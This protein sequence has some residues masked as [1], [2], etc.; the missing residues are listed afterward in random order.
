MLTL[1]NIS[2]VFFLKDMHNSFYYMDMIKIKNSMGTSTANLGR[3]CYKRCFDEA[4]FFFSHACSL[5]GPQ[6][7]WLHLNTAVLFS[8]LDV[9]VSDSIIPLLY[10]LGIRRQ[11]GLF[12]SDRTKQLAQLFIQRGGQWGY[13]NLPLRAKSTFPANYHNGSY[14]I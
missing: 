1:T 3:K 8:A 9:S 10:F 7:R 2:R 13:F 5:I 12:L 6:N 11:K 4:C 14:H